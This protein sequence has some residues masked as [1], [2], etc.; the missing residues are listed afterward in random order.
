[1]ATIYDA[2]KGEIQTSDE[3]LADDPFYKAGQLAQAQ[4]VQPQTSSQAVWGPM[5]Q[6]LVGGVLSGIGKRR[7]RETEFDAYKASGLQE[8][9]AAQLTGTEGTEGFGPVASGD[10]YGKNIPILNSVYMQE[11]APKGWTG[12]TGK[13]DLLKAAIMQEATA[14]AA[15]EQRKYKL[16]LQLLKDKGPIEATNARLIEAAK[17]GVKPT[18][19]DPK[20]ISGLETDFTKILTT[21]NEAKSFS[22]IK[23][24]GKNVLASLK[25]E[26]PISAASAIYGFAKILDPMGVVRREDGEMVADPGGPAGQLARLHN[27]ILQKGRL[28]DESRRTMAELVP[29]L[30]RNKQDTYEEMAAALMENAAK[31]GANRDNIGRLPGFAF[32]EEAA[33]DAGVPVPTG[34]FT[35]TGK[36]IV[37]LN[38]VKGVLE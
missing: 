34:E 35:K 14:K 36:P 21:G 13:K 38:G 15:E 24:S 8:A 19:L 20:E 28:T 27:E 18:G 1:M 29:I 9:M 16:E 26:D 10:V 11:D 4:M 23:T 30:V 6:A 3:Y 12:A 2:I 31:R 33:V 7:A 22:E 32:G 5:V 25:R 37:I 17:A